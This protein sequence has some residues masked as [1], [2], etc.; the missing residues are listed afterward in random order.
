MKPNKYIREL[1][2]EGF[3]E[4]TIRAVYLIPVIDTAWADG[5]VQAEERQEILELLEERGIQAGSGAYL[6]IDSWL[7]KKPTDDFFADA[8]DLIEPLFKDLKENRGGDIMWVIK[9]AERVASA[10]GTMDS[11]ISLG[12]QKVIK[13]IFERLEA[14]NANQR[15]AGRK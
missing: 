13:S 15:I 4:D 5:K 6:M 3:D 12:E 10:T 7:T 1:F 2:E 9:A 8:N 11:P 14:V